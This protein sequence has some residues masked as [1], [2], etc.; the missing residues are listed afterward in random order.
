MSDKNNIPESLR[1]YVLDEELVLPPSI[2]F[3]KGTD[4]QL[5]Y[6]PVDRESLLEVLDEMDITVRCAGP[7]VERD[8]VEGW[9]NEIRKALGVIAG[10]G[11]EHD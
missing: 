2:V 8:Y 1:K 10:K 11:Y 4:R 6:W 7:D 9:E 5:T 3:Y